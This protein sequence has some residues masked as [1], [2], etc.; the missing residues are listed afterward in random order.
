MALT[1]VF[2]NKAAH[3]KY[4]DHKRHL[5]FIK[6][7]KDSWKKVRVFDSIFFLAILRLQVVSR[8]PANDRRASLSTESFRSTTQRLASNAPQLDAQPAAA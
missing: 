4:Q 5:E 7:N 2:E 1:I 6:E 8:W 3:D